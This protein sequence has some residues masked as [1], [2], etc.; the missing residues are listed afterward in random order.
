[1][2]T[3]SER[4]RHTFTMSQPR[5]SPASPSTAAAILTALRLAGKHDGA[6]AALRA[7]GVELPRYEHYAGLVDDL[8]AVVGRPAGDEAVGRALALGFL[9]G[10]LASRRRGR[11]AAD[12]TS[13]LMDRELVVQSAEGESILRLP[14]FEDGLF[15]GRQLA[16]ISE[17][18][19]PI[20]TQ[21]VMH[22]SAALAGERSRFWFVSYGHAYWVDAV[23]VC[24]EDGRVD[25]VL[26]VATP[27]P[28]H[29]AATTAYERMAAR[30][31]AFADAA[32]RRA[33]LHRSAER[34]HEE[35]VA[36]QAAARARDAARR[37]AE[38]ARRLHS[39]ETIGTPA[40]PPVTP[41]EIEVLQ[42]SSHGLTAREIA[43]QL[44]L[45]VVT[46]KAHLHNIYPKLGVTDK[47]AAVAVAL[48]HGLID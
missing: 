37:T 19:A 16:D 31:D 6:E 23:P 33:E 9:A 42:L 45:S 29:I 13:F 28:S 39:R 32:E 15:V 12:P 22:Y 3:V 8:S 20:R 11:T 5:W 46:V 47:A 30:L 27:A 1:M 14:W 2:L 43:E 34:G 18:P 40:P 17:M 36:R 10:R 38:H 44:G 35:R 7:T 24:D 25:S 26:A 4:C 48:R 41:R 21:C